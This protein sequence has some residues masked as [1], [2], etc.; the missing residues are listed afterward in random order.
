MPNH[1]M[2]IIE[3]AA[4]HQDKVV[5][6]ITVAGK[7][8]PVVSF[9]TLIPFPVEMYRGDLAIGDETDFPCNWHKWQTEHWGTKWDAYDSGV[10]TQD[11]RTCVLFSTAWSVPYPFIA[12]FANTL[13]ISFEHRYFDEGHNFWG[14]QTWEVLP[15]GR[16]CRTAVR[17]NAEEDRRRLCMELMGYDP[18]SPQ[19]EGGAA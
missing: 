17:K 4:E 5:E 18:D 12:A 3:F 13:R 15:D 10:V 2:N 14:I 9:A 7:D 16:A 19:E 1:V 8:G 11:E 6:A